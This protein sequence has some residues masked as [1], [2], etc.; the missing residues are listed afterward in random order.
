MS[1]SESKYFNTAMLMNEALLLLLEDKNIDFISIK[2][3]C[4]R[5]GVNR[6]TFYLHYDT[7]D[8][9]F[10]ETIDMLNNRFKDSFICKDMKSTI[11]KGNKEDLFFIK[12][13]F[14]FP[15]LEFVKKIKEY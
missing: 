12:D 8:D 2:E 6:S 4:E 3:I 14:L 11:K 13:E 5:A 9:L 7:I 1:K 15:Y 10:A